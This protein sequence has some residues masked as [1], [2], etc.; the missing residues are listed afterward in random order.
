MADLQ[1]I[2]EWPG[3]QSVMAFTG[4][5]AHGV[6][7]GVFSVNCLPQKKFPKESGTLTIRYGRHKL[8]FK[9]CIIAGGSYRFDQS[10][11]VVGV[12]ILDRRWRWT[13]GLIA[14]QYN[15]RKPTGEIS[16]DADERALIKKCLDALGE[17]DADLSEVSKKNYPTI[18]W[19]SE[20]PA[21]ALQALCDQYGYRVVLQT[22]GRVKICVANDG[23]ELP[24]NFPY[25]GVGITLEKPP[26]PDSLM[27]LGAPYLVHADIKLEA[28]GY[29]ENGEA[30]RINRLSYA[31][32][33]WSAEP[34]TEKD[35]T[36][37]QK[38]LA[39]GHVWRTYKATHYYRQQ[40]DFLAKNECMLDSQDSKYF[41]PLVDRSVE[42]KNEVAKTVVWGKYS[43]RDG[44]FEF[45][46]ENAP[47]IFDK[48]IEAAKVNVPFT[49]KIDGDDL[50]VHFNEPVFV[51]NDDSEPVEPKLFLRALTTAHNKATAGVIRY[52]E[53][54]LLGKPANGRQLPLIIREESLES[55][56]FFG[57]KPEANAALR[58]KARTLLRE[59]KR[60]LESRYPQEAIYVGWHPI[61][62]DGAIQSITWSMGQNGARMAV[63]RNRDYGSP[64]MPSFKER[65]QFQKVNDQR[66]EIA[67]MKAA[68]ERAER[69]VR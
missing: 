7:P 38:A 18:S 62:L 42:L 29:E 40:D 16:A 59:K 61:E 10:G 36:D 32:A 55:V 48:D 47:G 33:D 50:F 2:V 64:V 28:Y 3:L 27:V 20:S 49:V 14:G 60:E 53:T 25:E 41:L 5:L 31:P 57:V 22:D 11:Q 51:Y 26:V 30:K 43:P 13:G 45:N 6:T 66:A 12:T 35:F 69:G 67:K 9:D 52:Y 63:Q 65:E 23:E 8:T 54:E 37:T 17:K 58:G 4:T 68:I 15:R 1:A 44:E 46:V 39:R 34:G 21:R 56:V 24:D 19:D